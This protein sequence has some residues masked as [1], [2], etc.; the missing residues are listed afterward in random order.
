MRAHG[1]TGT[2]IAVR[3]AETRVEAAQ[4]RCLSLIK[5]QVR[6]SMYGPSDAIRER[7]VNSG[8]VLTAKELQRLG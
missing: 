8:K 2:A 6:C 4:A 3:I 1:K 7:C 5:P